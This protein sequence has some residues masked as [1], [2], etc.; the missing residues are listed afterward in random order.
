MPDGANIKGQERESGA[1]RPRDAR[2]DLL[3][4]LMKAIHTDN[5]EVQRGQLKRLLFMTWNLLSSDARQDFLRLV[6]LA[7]PYSFITFEKR[8]PKRNDP[9]LESAAREWGYVHDTL[10]G[11][12]LSFWNNFGK[13]LR[14]RRNV[15]DKEAK[16]AKE[17]YLKWERTK[18]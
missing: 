7:P 13:A 5:K 1:V 15:S 2:D 6:D 10:A 18:Q 8:W 12:E 4:A 11:K 17:I 16:W 14:M 3:D 9:V